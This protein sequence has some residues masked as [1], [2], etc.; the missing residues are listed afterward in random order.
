MMCKVELSGE[1]QSKVL[2]VLEK[3][4]PLLHQLVGEGIIDKRC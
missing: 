1:E 4:R 2:E 3:E